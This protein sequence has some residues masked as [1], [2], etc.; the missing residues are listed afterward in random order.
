VDSRYRQDVSKYGKK[1]A[2]IALC[3][4]LLYMV[5]GI[6]LA[7]IGNAL[8]SAETLTSEQIRL[9]MAM[10]QL[11]VPTVIIAIVIIKKQG[12]K[13]IGIHKENL[14]PALRLGCLFSLIAIFFSVLPGILYGGNFVGISAI[15]SSLLWAFLFAFPEDIFFIGYLQTRLYGLFKTDKVA[16]GTGALIFAFMHVPTWIMMGRLNLENMPS[17]ALSVFG[18]LTA[19]VIYVLVFKRHFSLFPIFIMHTISNWALGSEF[20]VFADDYA[21]QSALEWGGLGGILRIVAVV[22]WAIVIH[23]RAKKATVQKDEI[24]K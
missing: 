9:L 20:W 16:I 13:S 5:L 8:E 3:V 12:L 1:D 14:W 23:R 6:T 15:M 2:L 19:H 11:F 4:L 7:I 18:W 21:T 22:V 10:M 24:L 17:F